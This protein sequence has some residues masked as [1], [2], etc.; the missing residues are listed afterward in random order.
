MK[1]KSTP[2]FARALTALPFPEQ[3]L[4]KCPVSVVHAT[5]S[6]Q[7]ELGRNGRAFSGYG[8]S[9][10]IRFISIFR[11]LPYAY[12]ARFSRPR[13]SFFLYFET[14]FASGVA[15][16]AEGEKRK[17]SP[18][19]LPAVSDYPVAFTGV[20]ECEGGQRNVDLIDRYATVVVTVSLFCCFSLLFAWTSQL[21]MTDKAKQKTLT[22]IGQWDWRR[23]GPQNTHTEITIH[24]NKRKKTSSSQKK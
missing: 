17:A 7:S 14:G 9:P 23:G 21:E 1:R 19:R 13:L 20:W 8:C 2:N 10:A 4:E 3:C 12:F 22:L 15:R 24:K 6:S 11:S 18:L 16:W 5:H